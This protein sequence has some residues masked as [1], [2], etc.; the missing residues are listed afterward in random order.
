MWVNLPTKLWNSSNLWSELPPTM[1]AFWGIIK[2]G[3]FSSAITLPMWTNFY[4]FVTVVFKFHN[5]MW[6]QDFGHGFRWVLFHLLLSKCSLK[7][8]H[9]NLVKLVCICHNYCRNIPGSLPYGSQCLSHLELKWL[10]LLPLPAF[11]IFCFCSTMLNL[12]IQHWESVPICTILWK[13][14]APE[15]A[16]G[17]AFWVELYEES[18]LAALGLLVR[19]IY[20][21]NLKHRNILHRYLCY[22]RLCLARASASFTAVRGVKCHSQIMLTDV[23]CSGSG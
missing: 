15:A 14:L 23:A 9:A 12:S 16:P 11:W 5:V 22:G 10:A 4:N 3:A 8:C 18:I 20:V 17:C 6:K 7:C 1:F 21:M 13:L 19:N 2:G